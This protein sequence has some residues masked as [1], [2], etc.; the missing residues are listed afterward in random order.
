MKK[1]SKTNYYLK[2]V[3]LYHLTAAFLF[4]GFYFCFR[5]FMV[6]ESFNKTLH[7]ILCLAYFSRRTRIVQKQKCIPRS[8]DNK[9]LVLRQSNRKILSRLQFLY[10]SLVYMYKET[11]KE[12]SYFVS[13]KLIV[14]Y[15]HAVLFSMFC[16]REEE[17]RKKIV[18]LPFFFLHSIPKT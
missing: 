8:T 7:I 15:Y 10:K 17:N 16:I 12:W 2:I 5:F 9:L 13:K 18:P 14:F 3:K 6:R 4:G 11:E 1:C